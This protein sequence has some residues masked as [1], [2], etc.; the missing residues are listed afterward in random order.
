[1]PDGRFDAQRFAEQARR[2]QVKMIE[3]KLSQG[4]SPAM[5]GVAGAKVSLEIAQAR[6]C[7]RS[8][9]AS[10]RPCTANFRRRSACSN[11]LHAC[12]SSRT[13]SRWA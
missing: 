10:R 13:A 2:A 6:A 7:R 1:M 5:G 3:I 9:I 11:S 4:P 8:P 12:A